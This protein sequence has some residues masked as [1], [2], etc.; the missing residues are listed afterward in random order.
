MIFARLSS[1]STFSP[2]IVF[3]RIFERLHLDCVHDLLDLQRCARPA[4]RLVPGLDSEYVP[5]GSSEQLSRFLHVR[6]VRRASFNSVV[7]ECAGFTPRVFLDIVFEF[8]EL[9]RNACDFIMRS[10]FADQPY[11][12]VTKTQN[13]STILSLPIISSILSP[14][15]VVAPWI[16]VTGAYDTVLDYADFFSA[17]IRDDDVL[18]SLYKLRMRESDQLKTV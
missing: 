1:G 13:G 17:T 4:P 8:V 6:L 10:T 3:L 5:V 18:E 7:V 11:S 12:D 9:S 2:C 15:S 16:C 14:S